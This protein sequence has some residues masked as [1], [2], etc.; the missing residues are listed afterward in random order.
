[1]IEYCRDLGIHFLFSIQLDDPLPQPINVDVI[2]V[3]V[4]APLH[5]MLAGCTGLPDDLEPHLTSGPLL[6]KNDFADHKSQ[7]ALA[8]GCRRGGRV[9]NPRQVLAERL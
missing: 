4:N 3:G 7:N 5:V 2:A 8:I 6:I 1:M 9:P